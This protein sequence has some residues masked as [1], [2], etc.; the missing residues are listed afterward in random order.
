MKSSVDADTFKIGA[1]EFLSVYPVFR[2]IMARGELGTAMPEQTAALES[3]FRVLDHLLAG[4]RTQSDARHLRNALVDSMCTHKAAY[5]DSTLVPTWHKA[6][7]IGSGRWN[8][9]PAERKH[10]VFKTEATKVESLKTFERTVTHALVNHQLNTFNQNGDRV[11]KTGVFLI[12]PV[13]LLDGR[14]LGFSG[15]VQAARGA[16]QGMLRTRGKDSI[17]MQDNLDQHTR[18][19]RVELHVKCPQCGMFILVSDYKKSLAGDRYE[20]SG[21]S[22]LAPLNSVLRTLIWTEAGTGVEL[23]WPPVRRR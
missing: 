6:L 18:V 15:H 2:L 10:K 11:F 19:A 21:S 5:P 3:M 8:T 22:S 1:S 7:H 16:S 14:A 9:L 23:A 17:E 12:G 4:P 13:V 20:P